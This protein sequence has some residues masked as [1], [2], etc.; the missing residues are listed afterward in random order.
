M[1]VYGAAALYAVFMGAGPL[2]KH[3]DY[4]T[5]YHVDSNDYCKF[6]SLEKDPMSYF[7]FDHTIIACH[8]N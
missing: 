7:T 5:F 6:N 3:I 2:K 4:T 8:F 1:N